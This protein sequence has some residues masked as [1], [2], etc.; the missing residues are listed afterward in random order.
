MQR[1]KWKTPFEFYHGAK[2]DM[3]KIRTFGCGAYV[4]LPDEIRPNKLSP[5][6]ELMIFL[7][8]AGGKNFKFMRHLSGNVKFVSPTAMFDE[9][10]FPK[11]PKSIPND[12][13]HREK[14][15]A[16]RSPSPREENN[17]EDFPSIPLGYPEGPTRAPAPQQGARPRSPSPGNRSPPPGAQRRTSVR[18]ASPS[19]E[20]SPSPE[21]PERQR[22]TRDRR[23]PRRE[24]NIYGD[25]SNPVEDLRR[26]HEWVIRRL[27]GETIHET[28]LYLPLNNVSWNRPQW[29]TPPA[30]QPGPSNNVPLSTEPTPIKEEPV[31]PNLDIDGLYNDILDGLCS[32]TLVQEGGVGLNNF[33]FEIVKAIDTPNKFRNLQQLPATEKKCWLDACL[34]ELKALK[35]RNVYELVDLPKGRRAI[36]NRWVFNQKG[37]GRLRARLVAKG[38]SQVEGIDFDEL[39]SPVVRYETARLLFGVTALEDWDMFSVDVKT[40]YLY[41][42]L[43]EE[44]Y[45][46]QPEGFK[47]P[48]MEN[49]VWRLRRALYGL[50][51]AGLSWWKELTT[52]MTE[53]GFVRCKSDAGVY[54]YR[55]P[56]TR[57]LVVA[58]VYVD[59]VGFMGKR[60]SQL[61]KELKQ[62]FSTKWEC[63]NQ[64]EL[65][66]F[67]GMEV[68][69]DRK[70]KRVF[71][72]QHKYLQKVLDRFHIKTGSEDT[73]LPKGFVFNPSDKVPDAKFRQK[74]QQL[75][76]SLMYL[77]IGSRPDIAYAVVKLS[78]QMVKPSKE[79]YS[80][81]IHLLRY[82]HGSKKLVLEFCGDC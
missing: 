39:F 47:I 75:V 63:R 42:K 70:K 10:Y 5:Q 68:S 11:C 50:K 62:K 25:C 56:K 23:P 31:G 29:R 44:I 45:M 72:Q 64:G 77:M 17:D 19:P 53:I 52:S 59:D 32:E 34:E 27:Q 22:P 48:G 18:S 40:A 81:G 65:T 66:E 46:Q 35:K 20:R 58:I 33:L 76:G 36:K 9:G 6:S 69:R 7:G 43:D 54:Y 26:D 51:Q 12:K 37:D 16:P 79:H 41:G 30:N 13:I 2:L 21:L 14:V 67:L 4:Y 74:Y 60:G 3:T 82:L 8:S 15:E 71:V 1:L 61:L 78:Q 57:K 80:A 24:G 55:H 28:R 38:F 49:K 73:P